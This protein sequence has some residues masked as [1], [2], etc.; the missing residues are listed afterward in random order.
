LGL[1]IYFFLFNLFLI[2]HGYTEKTLGLLTSSMA[3]GNLAGAI[4]AGKLAQRFGLR[5]VLLSC[6]LLAIAVSSARAILLSFSWQICL[7]FL[8]GVALSAWAICLSPAVAQ[9][10]DE[11][12]RP[13]AFSLVFSLGIGVGALGGLVGSR[14]PGWFASHHVLARYLQP[15]QLVLLL[16]CCIVAFGVWPATKLTFGHTKL[17]GRARPFLSPF[18]LRFLPAIAIWSLVTG[19]FSPFANVYFAQH[20]RMSLP[21][22]GNAFSISQIAQVAAV[23]AAPVIFRRWGLIGGIVS[24]QLVTAFL[25]ITLAVIG[26]PLAATAAYVGFT[27]FQWMNEPGLY[28]LLMNM[29]PAEE[30]GGA[31]ASNSLVMSASQAI[32]ATLAGAAFVRYGYPTTL[33]GIA[34]IALIAAALFWSMRA[35][36][37][38][39]PA[40][41]LDNLPG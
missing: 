13:F 22:I 38:L 28:S 34:L 35:Q 12:Q 29:V 10:T 26:H 3:I 15:D 24:T 17:P 19:S 33:C 25:L 8:A 7:A 32:A 39:E 20:L 37:K 14:L 1:S 23:L 41:E 5:P 4:P 31:S 2:G 21:Q 11:R 18:L 6:F 36:P 16:S 30:R 40:P 9:L 27:A